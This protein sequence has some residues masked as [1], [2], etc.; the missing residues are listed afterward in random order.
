MDSSCNGLLGLIHLNFYL[1]HTYWVS[2]KPCLISRHHFHELFLGKKYGSPCKCLA[3]EPRQVT[4]HEVAQ[5]A[6]E[7]Y[8]LGVRVLGGMAGATSKNKW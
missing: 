1:L 5:W 2:H 7:A 3:M 8:N 6:R 4:R